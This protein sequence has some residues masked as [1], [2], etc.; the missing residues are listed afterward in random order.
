MAG[1]QHG[2]RDC[3]GETYTT[4]CNS[5]LFNQNE[6]IDWKN[7]TS[8]NAA[9]VTHSNGYQYFVVFP[10]KNDIYNK[11]WDEMTVQ[12][13]EIDFY[14]DYDG[15]RQHF[16]PNTSDEDAALLFDTEQSLARVSVLP[17]TMRALEESFQEHS[18]YRDLLQEYNSNA[19]GVH[20]W[21]NMG[22]NLKIGYSVEKQKFINGS[23][24]LT[25]VPRQMITDDYI[26]SYFS[27]KLSIEKTS[28]DVVEEYIDW[29]WWNCFGIVGG[30]MSYL[31][32]AIVG[33]MAFFLAEK[34]HTER[35]RFSITSLAG[36][37]N[38]HIHFDKEFR[39]R[40]REFL[41]LEDLR[42][43]NFGGGVYMRTES[44]DE[45][46]AE[47]DYSPPRPMN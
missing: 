42:K 26:G 18:N 13:H 39:E 41:H 20:I 36:A 10:P 28:I 38:S 3:P 19:N 5:R 34:Y 16:S 46:N 24:E 43:N 32:M 21:V 47:A 33:L 4:D 17:Q 45:E 11:L 22:Q 40:L 44:E 25:T 14:I 23:E 6:K 30:L 7:F 31:R 15:W 27:I 35:D 29:S 37:S 8:E 2:V 1:T 9:T 12:S